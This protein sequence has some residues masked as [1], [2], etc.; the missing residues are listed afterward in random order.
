MSLPRIVAQLAGL[1]GPLPEPFTT[2]PFELVLWESI[3]YL[4]D[5][6]RRA[7]ALE[8]L[9]STVG[10]KPEQLLA[11]ARDDL[12]SVAEHGILADQTVSKLRAAAEIAIG[13]FGGDLGEVLAR[14]AGA[15]KK[16]LRRFPGI[17]EPGAEKILLYCRKHPSLAP[18]SN[19]L[20]VL[21]RF[22]LLPSGRSY[23]ATYTAARE[24]GREQL[25]DDFD[26]LLAARHYLRVHGQQ[27]CRRS[28]PRCDACVLRNDCAFGQSVSRVD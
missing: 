27:L 22:G 26:R 11:A 10:T 9:R 8:Q 20:R 7:Q 2:E 13:E 14:P 17:G 28:A 23:S 15:A 25:G 6:E 3:A 19:G 12:I 24:V 5:D 21:V 18:E 1:Y 4:A 16:A